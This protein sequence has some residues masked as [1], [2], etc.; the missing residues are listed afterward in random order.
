MMLTATELVL[1]VALAVT[2]ATTIAWLISMHH[3][4]QLQDRI[5]HLT[6]RLDDRDVTFTI[7]PN[8][9][10]GTPDALSVWEDI[11][12]TARKDTSL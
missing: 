8:G 6:D 9:F 3:R 4:D 2:L 10:H 11:I 5:N 7:D 1:I 12:N